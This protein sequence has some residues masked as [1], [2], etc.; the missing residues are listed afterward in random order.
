[1]RSLL[2]VPADSARKLEKS[3]TAQAD[4]L[5]VDLEDSVAPDNKEQAREMAA[6][7]V[8]QARRSPGAPD[9]Y[10]R[11]NALD[12]PWTDADLAAIMPYAPAGVMLPKSHSGADVDDLS[13]R[14]AVHEAELGLEDGVTRILV[15]ATE[16]ASSLFNLDTYQGVSDR[17]HGLSWGAE[18]L[19][20]DIGARSNRTEDGQFSEPFRLARN[21]CLFAAVAAGVTPIDTVF[22]NF[23]DIEGLRREAVAAERDGFTAK[24]AIHPDQV[25]IINDVFTP[26]AQAVARAR[27][28]V[29]AFAQAGGKGVI[30]IDGEM[31]DQPH[32]KRAEKLLRR[33]EPAATG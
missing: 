27:A 22:T 26:S 1:M 13:N 25:A 9:I 11:V 14:L 4:M 15:V 6:Q 16:T 8:G 3:L 21:L 5:L 10:L 30:A 24:M 28:I 19:S 20:A 12:S 29:E 2:F 31:L 33:A 23:R 7:F 18:D 32:L 17:L